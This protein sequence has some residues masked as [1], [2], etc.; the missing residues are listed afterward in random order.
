MIARL[1]ANI[2][3]MQK[4][5]FLPLLEDNINQK[6]LQFH[7]RHF[8]VKTN[9][10]MLWI[11]RLAAVIITAIG[12]TLAAA[13]ATPAAI[14]GGVTIILFG[15]LLFLYSFGMPFLREKL[16]ESFYLSEIRKKFH[17]NEN[18]SNLQNVAY[19]RNHKQLHILL[20]TEQIAQ[21]KGLLKGVDRKGLSF[22]ISYKN[23]EENK[24][25]IN[26][27]TLGKFNQIKTIEIDFE[28]QT[29][30]LEKNPIPLSPF[31]NH[32]SYEVVN[33]LTGNRFPD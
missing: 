10:A 31:R 23:I 17:C 21:E 16:H 7:G 5:P 24:K 29:I 14:A 22:L 25:E 30:P 9:Q 1:Q 18:F 2:N 6:P 19:D 20:S 32:F 8:F 12:I 3:Q 28:G 27:F 33:R 13:I 26:L 11:T 15:S 4:N